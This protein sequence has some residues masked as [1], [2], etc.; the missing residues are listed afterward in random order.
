MLNV[1]E[2]VAPAQENLPLVFHQDCTIE[3]QHI[4][5]G[6]EVL[7]EAIISLIGANTGWIEH[8]KNHGER[9]GLLKQLPHFSSVIAVDGQGC[10]IWC[11]KDYP[12]TKKSRP[13]TW[14]W[15][16]EDALGF[17]GALHA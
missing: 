8:C 5:A 2:S 10:R 16:L 15:R 14:R 7:F 13:A 12:R 1:G 9:N 6:L 3:M 11:L 4:D 17:V